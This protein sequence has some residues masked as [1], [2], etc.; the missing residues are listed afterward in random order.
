[1]NRFKILWYGLRLVPLLF[2]VIFFF[3]PLASIFEFSLI[4]DGRLDLSGFF[5]IATSAYYRETLFFTIYQAILSTS[6]RGYYFIFDP[7]FGQDQVYWGMTA[8]LL[9]EM[10]ANDTAK[11]QLQLHSAA[12]GTNDINMVSSFHGFLAC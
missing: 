2:L 7:D 8:S 10:D 6:N 3:F 5:T 12:S 11:V 1:M 9:V 4:A